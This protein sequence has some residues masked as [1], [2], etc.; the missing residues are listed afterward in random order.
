MDRRADRRAWNHTAADLLPRPAA[1]QRV[2]QVLVVQGDRDSLIRPDIQ[3]R[4]VGRLC[5][6]GQH[7]EYREVAGAGHLDVD[8]AAAGM[9]VDWLTDRLTAVPTT[10]TCAVE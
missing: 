5:T 2:G 9:V 10:S 4:F 3:R 1:P 6:S 8:D 7:V